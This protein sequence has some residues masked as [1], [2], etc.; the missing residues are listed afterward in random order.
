MESKPKKEK[1]F[2]AVKMMREIR[3]GIAADTKHMSFEEFKRYIAL[4]LKGSSI[5]VPQR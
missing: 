5:I 1:A 2:D 4:K 3:D